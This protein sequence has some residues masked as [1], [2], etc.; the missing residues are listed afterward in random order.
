MDCRLPIADCRFEFTDG[1]PSRVAA[2][3][4][5]SALGIRHSAI[6]P[7]FTLV[8]VLV[9]IAIALLLIVG[10]SKIFGLAQQASGMG[11]TLSRQ[12]DTARTIQSVLS[13]DFQNMVTDTNVSAGFVISS[14]AAAAFR[15]VQ[16]FQTGPDQ[17]NPMSFPTATNVT[18]ASA[19]EQA[20]STNFRIHRLD[21]MCFFESGFF[22]RQ[23]GDPTPQG[24]NLVS[25]NQSR[26]AFVWLGHLSIP[27]NDAISNWNYLQPDLP[28]GN[29]DYFGPGCFART[30]RQATGALHNDNNLYASS[31]ILGRQV[32]V[33]TSSPTVP[34]GQYFQHYLPGGNTL[35]VPLSMYL[36][37][38]VQPARVV[39]IY[40]SRVD[41]S[42]NSM[43][44]IQKIVAQ[45]GGNGGYTTTGDGHFWWESLGGLIANR[46]S[47]TIQADRRYFCN[48]LPTKPNP[49]PTG[50]P[51]AQWLSASAAQTAP[52]FVRGCT[53]FIVEFA[54]DYAAQNSDGSIN[55][56]LQSQ[57]ITDNQIDFIVDNSDP[58]HPQRRI[59]WYGF[60]RDTGTD[61]GTTNASPPV[62]DGALD[63]NDVMPVSWYTNGPV[64]GTGRYQFERAIPTRVGIPTSQM[65]LNAVGVNLPTVPAFS[66]DAYVCAW[67]PDIPPEQRPKLI[68]ITIAI[69]EPTGRLNSEQ[70][71]E[72]IYAV[73]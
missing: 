65:P 27:N 29:G 42:Y 21:H 5:H 67:G 56:R 6:S 50:A 45:L 14:Y 60:P 13:N 15:N 12:N 49:F 63:Y 41:I 37:D 18:A 32:I 46:I 61:P 4:N 11:T 3:P 53:Q 19:P 36:P 31:W 22:Q 69:D 55:Q 40:A 25:I 43:S 30:S 71:Y 24:A 8:E 51:A 35:I 73:P 70:Y 48:P 39:P 44:D 47:G 7:A 34:F 2:Q 54:G 52:I 16:D 9:S 38:L 1:R 59:R 58:A 62:P 28:N 33:L 10:I 23:T 26:E 17:T 66:S 72:F 64:G 20:F 57:G 68:R